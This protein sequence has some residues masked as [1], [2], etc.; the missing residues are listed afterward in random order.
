MTDDVMEPY[1]EWLREI[2]VRSPNT[3]RAMV[4]RGEIPAPIQRNGR[5][6]MMRSW[7]I[8]Y[9]QRMAASRSRRPST[10]DARA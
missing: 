3:G 8:D 9:L 4:A 7:R 6:Y 10:R 5:L 2:G 1:R